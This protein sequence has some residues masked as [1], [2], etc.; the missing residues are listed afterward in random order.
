MAGVK[1]TSA[2][3]LNIRSGEYDLVGSV[4]LVVDEWCD[5]GVVDDDQ[6]S[7]S[8]MIEGVVE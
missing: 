7:V 3:R 4:S 5:V 6:L 1:Q 2:F 8:G